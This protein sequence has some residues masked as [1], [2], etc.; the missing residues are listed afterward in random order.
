MSITFDFSNKHVFVAGGTSGIN[1][2]IAD[3]FARAGANVSVC[4]R[5]PAKI[6]AAQQQL[7][8]Y[9]RGVNGYQADVRKYDD[10][11]NALRQAHAQFGDIDVLVSGA[12]GN[13]VAPAVGIS[14]N[15]FRTVVEIDLLGTFHVMRAAHQFL[16][17]P[18]ASLINISAD[19]A[20]RP[21]AGQVHVCAAKAGIDQIT[22][23][24]ALEWAPE[25]I[26]VNSIA[27]GP[28]ADT[29]GMRRLAS[30]P[31]AEAKLT[32]RLPLGRYGTKQ[33]I[34]SA[35]MFLSSSLGEYITGIVLP[36]DGGL[37]IA[38]TNGVG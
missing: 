36:V 25:G 17:K 20:M 7:A 11:E 28:I 19:Q 12:A 8:A 4:S 37:S 2:G 9:G 32:A 6:E 31:E 3:A 35:C 30:T 29:E 16:R 23:V 33:E 22:R 15:G 38:G 24:L 5:D 21:Y 26:R 34:A 10:V 14:S 18:G 13:F 27:P 1:L